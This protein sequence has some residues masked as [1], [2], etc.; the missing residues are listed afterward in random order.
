MFE[1]L[2][3]SLNLDAG[4]VE[5][6][7]QLLAAVQIFSVIS[8]VA[9]LITA[10]QIRSPSLSNI[11]VWAS[12]GIA[13]LDPIGTIVALVRFRGQFSTDEHFNTYE[14]RVEEVTGDIRGAPQL[15]TAEGTTR[16]IKSSMSPR[17]EITR[18]PESLLTVA[19]QEI[20]IHVNDLLESHDQIRQML[21]DTGLSVASSFGSTSTYGGRPQEFVISFSENTNVRVLQTVLRIGIHSGAKWVS[22]SEKPKSPDKQSIHIGAYTYRRRDSRTI[23]L[24]EGIRTVLLSPLLDRERLL[25]TFGVPIER[26][27]HDLDDPEKGEEKT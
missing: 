1:R 14:N 22:L 27:V 8:V 7:L 9:F 17:D 24:D 12:V 2:S 19:K 3:R 23:P 18:L 10:C 21:L 11:L 4:T 16:S 6:P 20:G 15:A 25:L 5:K 13:I 26:S